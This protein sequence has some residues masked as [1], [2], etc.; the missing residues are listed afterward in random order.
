MKNTMNDNVGISTAWYSGRVENGN[1]LLDSMGESGLSALEIDYRVTEAM[2]LQM[3]PR[4]R[5]QEFRVLTV[6]NY[7][8]TPPGHEGSDNVASLFNPASLDESEREQA[9]RYGLKSIEVAAELGARLVVFHLGAVDMTCEMR[10]LFRYYEQDG[11]THPDFI[12]YLN[13]VRETRS[14]LIGQHWPA[15]MRTLEVLHQEAYR[16][17]I[18]IGIENRYR[19][20]QIP[21]GDEFATIFGEF[22]G[23]QMRYWHDVGHAEIYHRLGVYD[24]VRDYLQPNQ[25]H[26]AGMHIHDIAGIRDHLAPGMGDFDFGLLEP[27]LKPDTLRIIEVHQHA[28]AEQVRRGVERL[29][30]SG[31]A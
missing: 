2:L 17:G 12:D 19:L 3:W 15:L 5:R 8:P 4:L 18:L 20:S 24:H 10:R 26:L 30:E 27:F 25:E 1:A 6:H 14:R 29:H 23:G 11:L 31:L 16:S 13:Q 9:V 22:S 7:C 21:F 28:D